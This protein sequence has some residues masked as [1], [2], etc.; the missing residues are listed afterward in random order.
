MFF[1][2]TTRIRVQWVMAPS[3]TKSIQSRGEAKESVGGVWLLLG[4]R[5]RC[6]GDTR[7]QPG[8]NT[9][10]QKDSRVLFALP[11]STPT[12]Y[13]T[14]EARPASLWG[15]VGSWCEIGYRLVQNWLICLETGVQG[16]GIFLPS[17]SPTLK[18]G[19][20]T[21]CLMKFCSGA[22]ESVCL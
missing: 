14:D 9:T 19:P 2:N 13:S 15:L 4:C 11:I 8:L 5:V 18:Q 17:I 6:S 12:R 10:D 20:V 3:Q 7:A 16:S 22:F 1:C 21:Q